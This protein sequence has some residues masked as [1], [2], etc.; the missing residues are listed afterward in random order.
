M[1]TVFALGVTGYIGGAVV[2]GWQR[3]FP[4]YEFVGLVR[5]EKNFAAVEGQNPLH[6]P[7]FNHN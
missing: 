1:P 6:Y 7:R 4:D 3:A 2:V 5:S